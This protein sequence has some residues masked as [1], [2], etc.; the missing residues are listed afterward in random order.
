MPIVVNEFRTLVLPTGKCCRT[1]SYEMDEKTEEDICK[2][3]MG[4]ILTTQ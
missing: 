4:R 2:Y 3:C 1:F